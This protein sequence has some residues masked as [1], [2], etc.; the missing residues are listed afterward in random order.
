[1][2]A[3]AMRVAGNEEG[4]GYGGKSDGDGGKGG[5]QL[6]AIRAMAT[7]VAAEQLQQGQWQQQ[8]QQ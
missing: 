3:M 7:R 6:T 1:M 8:W 4:N 2:M 5:R